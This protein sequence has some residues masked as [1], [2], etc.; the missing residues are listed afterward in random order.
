MHVEAT[1]STPADVDLYLQRKLPDGTW[2]ADIV[3]GT[4]GSLSGEQLDMGRLTPG[5]TYR[6][7]AHLWA[8]LPATNIA[9]TAT[10]FNSAGI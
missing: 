9:I 2:T 10:F 1:P 4:S 6:I 5:E 7:E 3:A 8:G